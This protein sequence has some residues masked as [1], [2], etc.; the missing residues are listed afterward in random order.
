MVTRH[1][2]YRFIWIDSL[3]IFH[4]S[5]D[6]WNR[7]AVSTGR[8]YRNS[9][10]TI[11]A[12]GA[13]D[14]H[15][16]CF[17]KRNPLLYL[18]C[19]LFPTEDG[20]IYA[21]PPSH[22]DDLNLLFKEALLFSRAWVVQELLLSPRTLHFGNTLVWE[23][24]KHVA[25]ESRPQG[26]DYGQS[27]RIFNHKK[28]LIQLQSAQIPDN[29]RSLYNCFFLHWSKI[30]QQYT[31]GDL[32]YDKDRLAGLSGIITDLERSTGLKSYSGLWQPLLREGLLWK[33]PGSSKDP[34]KMRPS[35]LT[36]APTWSWTSII[37]PVAYMRR[38]SSALCR[39]HDYSWL[40]NILEAKV[41]P[42]PA[43]SDLVGQ[44]SCG[45]I[46]DL[47]SAH[48]TCLEFADMVQLHSRREIGWI[49]I[50]CGTLLGWEAGSIS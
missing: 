13:A 19:R 4:D 48:T 10:C 35:R 9:T 36:A 45:S 49:S 15:R 21:L 38:L 12:V 1:L 43:A 8:V 46:N 25:T 42:T 40:A 32:T 37:S 23:C 33:T 31:K 17:T 29:N 20:D 18:P 2:R 3:C 16:R 50:S 11:S 22:V 44:V 34:S 14:S 30:V 28:H 41:T 5:L 27:H 47:G 7:E 24:Q 39:D 6:D 26:F